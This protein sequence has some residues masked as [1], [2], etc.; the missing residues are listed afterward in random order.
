MV[1]DPTPGIVVLALE[2]AGTEMVLPLTANC[3]TRTGSLSGSDAFPSKL[4][5]IGTSSA[6]LTDSLPSIGGRIS[7]N[8]TRL[9]R[10]SSPV[11]A[12]AVGA[13]KTSRS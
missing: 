3:V 4:P 8:S 11:E 10:K 1:I 6:V 13:E 12:F 7:T 9:T 5:E 2:P